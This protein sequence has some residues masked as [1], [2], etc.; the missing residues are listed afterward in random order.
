MGIKK[1]ACVGRKYKLRTRWY[2]DESVM[3]GTSL[4]RLLDGA[5]VSSLTKVM[6]DGRQP[7][8]RSH[9]LQ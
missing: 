4:A 2:S 1:D 8:Q 5:V 3:S 9:G 6:S 7:L